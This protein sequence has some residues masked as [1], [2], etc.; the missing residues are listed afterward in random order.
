M[1]KTVIK[2]KR[3]G[4]PLTIEVD[5]L[6]RKSGK[7][8]RTFDIMTDGVGLVENYRAMFNKIIAK[9]GF[10]ALLGKMRKKLAAM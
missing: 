9:S 10:D 1:V 7:S 4:R 3:K 8:L 5:Y 6:L 2:A